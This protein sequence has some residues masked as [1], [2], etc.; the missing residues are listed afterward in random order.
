MLIYKYTIYKLTLIYKHTIY[1]LMLI[2]EYT[3]YNITNILI[4]NSCSFKIQ[5]LLIY[6]T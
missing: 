4:T 3:I 1:K 6:A 5:Q 2:Y